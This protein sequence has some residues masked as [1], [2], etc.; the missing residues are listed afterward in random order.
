M[1][2]E[3]ARER[4]ITAH[5]HYLEQLRIEQ[6]RQ[7][8]LYSEL[9]RMRYDAMREKLRYA[10]ASKLS[11]R[12]PSLPK[13]MEHDRLDE[14]RQTYR[15]LGKRKYEHQKL[16]LDIEGILNE[17][18]A[19]LIEAQCIVKFEIEK[20]VKNL[21][22]IST[23]PTLLENIQISTVWRHLDYLTSG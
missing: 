20:S 8:E 1:R 6:E 11:T 19:I 15:N 17:R 21:V 4:Y 2:L 10:Y 22:C 18:Q 12:F 7:Q 16:E 9:N 13:P 5:Q 3:F 23:S 14:L